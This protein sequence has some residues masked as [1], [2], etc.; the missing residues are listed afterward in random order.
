[1]AKVARRARAAN[2]CKVGSKRGRDGATF[3]RAVGKAAES[4]VGDG[5]EADAA[6]TITVTLCGAGK[7]NE[8]A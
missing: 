1:M 7:D 4:G 3:K 5:V 8:L 2:P 6:P